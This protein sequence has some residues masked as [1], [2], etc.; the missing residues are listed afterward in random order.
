M[1]RVIR[2]KKF[3][4]DMEKVKKSS[5]PNTWKTIQENLK[6]ALEYIVVQ[7]PLPPEYKDHKMDRAYLGYRN[8]HILGD[9]VLVYQIDKENNTVTLNRIGSHSVLGLT[10][11]YVKIN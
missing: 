4:K 1:L 9:V 3:I 5:K 6:E 10:E 8:C 2:H 7:K 11:E